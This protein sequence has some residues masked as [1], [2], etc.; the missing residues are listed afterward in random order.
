M[1][2][3]H[4]AVVDTVI[5]GAGP[6]GLGMARTL[7]RLGFQTVVVERASQAGGLNGASNAFIIPVAQSGAEPASGG[8]HFA[9]IDL[10]VPESLV[11][12]R[13]ALQRC[14]AP[15][16][17]ILASLFDQLG[18]P[19]ALIDKSGLM[20]MLVRQAEAAGSEFR[21]DTT[22][23]SL[24]Y[25]G[26]RVTGVHTSAGDVRAAITISAEG[27]ARSLCEQANLY[28]DQARSGRQ[29]LVMCQLDRKSVV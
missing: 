21:W 23:T 27:A 9:P 6:A 11:L 29:T 1:L 14:L 24:I 16:G 5:V 8:I 15:N 25:D 3:R 22:A 18:D 4:D 12:S 17:E 28:H 7:S 13:R 10:F 20:R 26:D 2:K 19:A